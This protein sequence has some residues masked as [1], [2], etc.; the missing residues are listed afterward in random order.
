MCDLLN[1]FLSTV[2]ACLPF[3]NDVVNLEI[4]KCLIIIHLST[5][6]H[7]AVY[8]MVLQIQRILRQTN[9]PTTFLTYLVSR[10]F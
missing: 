8:Y 6:H 10:L 4:L 1:P 9:H 5:L 2:S 3:A 7:D